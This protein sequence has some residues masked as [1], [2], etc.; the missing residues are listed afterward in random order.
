MTLE[1]ARSTATQVSTACCKSIQLPSA[2]IA[3]AQYI[4]DLRPEVPFT[5]RLD[6][7]PISAVSVALTVVPVRCTPASSVVTSHDLVAVPSTL[8]FAS[9]TAA[10]SS[11]VVV[12]GST[13]GCFTLVAQQSAGTGLTLTDARSLLVIEKPYTPSKYEQ[14]Y[15]R[16]WRRGQKGAVM[17]YEFACIDSID[18]VVNKMHERKQRMADQIVDG[19]TDEWSEDDLDEWLEAE[20]AA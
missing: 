2:P 8:L 6:A 14:A 12:R 19:V 17:I 9:H 10:L 3:V 11:T 4:A 5:V 13:L 7:T 15:K 18:E 16:V 1:D 20:G